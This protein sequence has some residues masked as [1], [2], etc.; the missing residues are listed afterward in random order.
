[1][2]GQVPLADPNA[3]ASVEMSISVDDADA[4]C[5]ALTERGVSIVFG[6]G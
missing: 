1:M 2:L 4:F 6:T 3:G 5:A